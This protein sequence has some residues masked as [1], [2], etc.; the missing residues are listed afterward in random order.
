ML[1]FLTNCL[2][3]QSYSF[4]EVEDPNPDKGI[5]SVHMLGD[6]GFAGSG[7]YSCYYD[8]E[9]LIEVLQP[10]NYTLGYIGGLEREDGTL[11]AFQDNFYRFYQWDNST[12]N[13]V[14]IP[15][16]EL[17]SFK[18]ISVL[19]ENNV[20]LCATNDNDE[21]YGSIYHYDGS[22]FTEFTYDFAYSYMPDGIY[23]KADN[24]ILLLA[25]STVGVVGHRLIRFDGESLQT[26]HT[27]TA[28]RGV[29]SMTTFD[30]NIFFFL[31][32]NGDVYKWDDS[33]ETMEQLYAYPEEEKYWFAG[34]I[35]AIDNNNIF[36][37]GY[38]GIRHMD[39]FTRNIDLIYEEWDENR[40]IWDIS[41]AKG[42][43]FF[44]TN[45]GRLIKMTIS[46]SIDSETVSQLNIYPNPATDNIT[47]EFPVFGINDKTIEILDLNGKIVATTQFSSFKVNV[48]ISGLSNGVYFLRLSCEEGL[49]TKKFIKNG[50]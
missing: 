23:A 42:K 44:A 46:N 5:N 37:A 16:P 50:E 49:I 4:I 7:N 28:G 36:I 38:G 29:Y 30:G 47:I 21:R 22:D 39:V 26:L 31:S 41:Y 14:I 9:E 43:A 25:S 8:G 24:D 20:Y 3:G 18:G 34:G 27:F 45:D 13:W 48:D 10:I 33:T 6:K 17:R 11:Y 35:F 19:A 12:E 1:L 32:S 40:Y 15:K 2:V